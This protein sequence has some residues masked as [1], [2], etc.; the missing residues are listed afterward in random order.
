MMSDDV[1]LTNATIVGRREVFA[2]S[3]RISGETIAAVDRG[4]CALAGAEDLGG[5]MLVPGLIELHTDNAEA[6]LEPRNGV[7]WPFPMA[8]VLAHDAQLIGAGI[9]T[10]LDAIAIGEYQD[11]GSRRQLLAEL[12]AAIRHARAEDLLRADHQLHLRCE[13]SDPCVVELFEAHGGDPL[14]RLVSLMDH[15]P[16]QRQFR[17]IETWKRF[18]RARMGDEAEMERIL[19]QGLERQERTVTGHRR[20]VVAFCRARAIR[21][22]SH[23][24]TTEQHVSQALADGVTIAEFPVTMAAATL[25]HGAGL[26]TV[27][28]APNIV[29]GGSHS[30]NMAAIDLARDGMLDALSSDYAP[31]SLLHA[32]FLLSERLGMAL[33]DALAL[34]SDSVASMLGLDDRG[35][36]EAGLRADLLWVRLC[37]GLPV[38]RAVWRGGRR[39]L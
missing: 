18:H 21:L 23:D 25:A 8:A 38:V 22:A 35:R 5:D 16:G 31:M 33:P 27:M 13:L 11:R 19:N 3:L 29:R 34:V 39:V 6:H 4:G 17:D 20:A 7:R 26:R 15:T 32:P 37:D 28:G 10:V 12:I 9:T 2:G 24:D 14:V 1:L 36:I 30:G